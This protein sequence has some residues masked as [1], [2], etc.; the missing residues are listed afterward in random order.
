MPDEAPEEDADEAATT[1]VAGEGVG[2]LAGEA[3]F[4]AMEAVLAGAEVCLT[5]EGTGAAEALGVATVVAEAA[6]GVVELA[7]GVEGACTRAGTGAA[8][9]GAAGEARAAGG[10]E[11]AALGASGVGRTSDGRRPMRSLRRSNWSASMR[12]DSA[13]RAFS[14]A[15]AADADADADDRGGVCGSKARR[16]ELS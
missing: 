9:G 7:G 14:S 2:V 13:S 4:A 8:G 5:G 16:S 11:G 1:V 10:V 15:A 3:F 12:S 6:V